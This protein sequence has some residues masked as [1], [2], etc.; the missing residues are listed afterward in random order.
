MSLIN[1]SN[2]A[3][4]F[5]SVITLIFSTHV[6]VLS[7]TSLHYLPGHIYMESIFRFC[8]GLTTL[9]SASTLENDCVSMNL[10]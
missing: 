1:I 2:S 7:D 4:T 10:S 8:P 3:I 5:F 9:S 6:I